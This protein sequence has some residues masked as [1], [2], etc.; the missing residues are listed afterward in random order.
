VIKAHN[1]RNITSYQMGVRASL[2]LDLL[3]TINPSNLNDEQ[4]VSRAKQMTASLYA[5]MEKS[6]AHWKE[7]AQNRSEALR[8][9]AERRELRR[10]N[11]D[12]RENP[13]DREEIEKRRNDT[14]ASIA[15]RFRAVSRNLR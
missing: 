3:L 4:E 5:D 14:Q 15:N 8:A 2:I 1:G 13:L 9:A 7:I 10:G 6:T 11:Y 12:N